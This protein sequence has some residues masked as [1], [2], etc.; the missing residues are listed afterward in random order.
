VRER[1]REREREKSEGVS[2]RWV[3]YEGG[4]APFLAAGMKQRLV[5]YA[6]DV[7]LELFIYIYIYIA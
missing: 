7:L 1:E 5:F 6:C 4:A 3:R 2:V